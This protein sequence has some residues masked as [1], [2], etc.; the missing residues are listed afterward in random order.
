M[1]QTESPFDS[2]LERLCGPGM[3]LAGHLYVKWMAS[4]VVGQ[5]LVI[6]WFT[7]AYLR[8]HIPPFVS[9]PNPFGTNC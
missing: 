9:D 1:Q 4:S 3:H 5:L 6:C 7:H 2:S 8:W